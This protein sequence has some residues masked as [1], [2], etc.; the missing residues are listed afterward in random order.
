MFLSAITVGELNRGIQRPPDSRHRKALSNWLIGDLLIGFADR[1][2]PLDVPVVMTWG[3]LVARMEADGQ[4]IPAIDSLLAA[5]AAQ[6]VLVMATHNVRD[7]KP[8]GISIINPWEAP[9]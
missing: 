1:V 7:F 8:T 5:T 3:G 6:H 9:P 2:L 4:Q